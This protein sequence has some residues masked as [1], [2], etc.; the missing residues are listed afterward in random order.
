MRVI[1][2]QTYAIGIKTQYG[3]AIKHKTKKKLTT[4][5]TTNNIKITNFCFD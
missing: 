4:T 5:T 2:R 3:M 1:N